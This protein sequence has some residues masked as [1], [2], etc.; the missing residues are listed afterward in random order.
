MD[1]LFVKKIF[2][3]V[4]GNQI[5]SFL[6]F[7]LVSCSLW[8]SLTLNRV[9]ETNISVCVHIVGIPDN[10]R[11]VNGDEIEVGACV[12][13]Y[14]TD[15]FGYIFDDRVDVAVAYADFVRKGGDLAIPV[16]VIKGQVSGTLNT[17][18]SLCGFSK[19]TLRATVQSA[20]MLVPV[21]KDIK[22]LATSQGYELVSHKY[23]HD[24]VM[25]TAYVDVLPSIKAVRIEPLVCND[26]TCDSV[27]E[28]DIMPGSYISV[29]PKTVNV[30][31]DVSQYI[32]KE[33]AVY[34]EYAE[35]PSDFLFNMLPPDAVVRFKVLEI[36][37]EK[38][39]ATD[40]SVKLLYRDCLDSVESSGGDATFMDKFK[41]SCMSPYVGECSLLPLDLS[42]LSRALNISKF[43]YHDTGD[44]WNNW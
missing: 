40:F 30:Y 13:G 41:I 44:N 37:A 24:S 2:K 38:V 18:V 11:L 10:V 21:V 1:T 29:S 39:N 20:S 35:F 8:F 23:S 14:G 25:V 43:H 19:D 32:E 33:V 42:D 34:V 36:N 27:F 12:K 15:L 5:F 16:D 17:S 28:L 22:R 3:K 7:L 26:L 9:Y 4:K 6:F 31:A